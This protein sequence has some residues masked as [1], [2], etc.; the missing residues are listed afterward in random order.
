MLVEHVL[1]VFAFYVEVSA[2]KCSCLSAAPGIM[3]RLVLD[4]VLTLYKSRQLHKGYLIFILQEVK[5]IFEREVNK[6]FFYN[7][8]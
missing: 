6:T 4:I 1:W 3:R 2:H 8:L 7:F 5:L